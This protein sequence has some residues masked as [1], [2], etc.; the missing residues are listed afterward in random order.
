MRDQVFGGT[1]PGTTMGD[2]T[3][4]EKGIANVP[5]VGLWW[6]DG[7]RIMFWPDAGND[8]VWFVP[9]DQR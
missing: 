8:F 3:Y 2:V 7:K 6:M 5:P 9:W 1:F 4:S